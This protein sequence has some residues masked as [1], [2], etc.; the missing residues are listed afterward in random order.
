MFILLF[1]IFCFFSC[2]G[3]YFS[4]TIFSAYPD[5]Y[6]ET[7]MHILCRITRRIWICFQ[8][9]RKI[10]EIGEFIRLKPKT[11]DFSHKIDIPG[12]QRFS[13]KL[14]LGFS[15]STGSF[16]LDRISYSRLGNITKI[17]I[18]SSKINKKSIFY[19]I[20]LFPLG[21]VSLVLKYTCG[22]SFAKIRLPR[23]HRPPENVE[24]LGE[25]CDM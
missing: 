23:G 7:S 9:F 19:H 20:E 15:K 4:S 14:R 13:T 21:N 18:K 25:R 24:F 5:K 10:Q 6:R 22:Q 1:T 3:F 17:F 16:T 2:M 8:K 11:S 12:F